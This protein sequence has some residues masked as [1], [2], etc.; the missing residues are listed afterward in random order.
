MKKKL[1]FTLLTIILL[2]FNLPQGSATIQKVDF[3]SLSI[4]PDTI[5]RLGLPTTI[6]VSLD[7]TCTKAIYMLIVMP[8]SSQDIMEQIKQNIKDESFSWWNFKDSIKFILEG[9]EDETTIWYRFSTI[10]SGETNARARL[11]RIIFICYPV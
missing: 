2:S 7:D 9:Y 5:P 6:S 8:P 4:T 1:V 10:D 3:L 11:A